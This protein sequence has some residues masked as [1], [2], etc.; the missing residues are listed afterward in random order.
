[1]NRQ[2]HCQLTISIF[3]NTA[4]HLKPLLFYSIS[5]ETKTTLSLVTAAAAKVARMLLILAVVGQ[6]IFM[7]VADF[8]YQGSVTVQPAFGITYVV[9]SLLQVCFKFY[10]KKSDRKLIRGRNL[11]KPINWIDIEVRMAY[12]DD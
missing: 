12:F 10:K 5:S 6:I 1:M 9:C 2:F 8:V 3:I 7:V 4:N 11:V